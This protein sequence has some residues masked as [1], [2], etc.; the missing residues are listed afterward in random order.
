VGRGMRGL[1]LL[2]GGEWGWRV[3]GGMSSWVCG[4]GGYEEEDDGDG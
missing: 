4:G 3:E 1:S 2:E